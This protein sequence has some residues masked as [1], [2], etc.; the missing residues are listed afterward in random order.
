MAEP[1]TFAERA[2]EAFEDR[3][4]NCTERTWVARPSQYKTLHVGRPADQVDLLEATLEKNN[5]RNVTCDMCENSWAVVLNCFSEK[6]GVLIHPIGYSSIISEGR[7]LDVCKK[8][9][10]HQHY[11]RVLFCPAEF[12]DDFFRPR[13]V[14]RPNGLRFS[15][16]DF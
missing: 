16:Q 1:M 15:N 13:I 3:M 12:L 2:K 10:E 4:I 7:R 9:G 8:C 11:D 5:L 6:E 14:R